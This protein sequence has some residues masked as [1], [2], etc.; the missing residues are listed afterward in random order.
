MPYKVAMRRNSTGEQRLV[1]VRD[2]WDDEIS[3]YLWTDGNF[4]CDCNRAGFWSEWTDHD[5]HCGETE[6]TALCA[7]L[8][9]GRKIKLDDD[10]RT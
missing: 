8:P 4:A 6:Y 1:D 3:K 10:A 9:D 5:R 2:D 7:E